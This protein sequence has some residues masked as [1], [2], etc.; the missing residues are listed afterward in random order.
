MS[1]QPPQQQPPQQ[2][3]PGY[4]PQPPPGGYAYPPPQQ[5]PQMPPALANLV[6]GDKA[7][8]L[9]AAALIVGLGAAL[10][11]ML[12]TL[13]AVDSD[14]LADFG[15]GERLKLAFSA[16]DLPFVGLI[17][18]ALALYRGAG[19]G[20]TEGAKAPF[21]SLVTMGGTAV[22]GLTLL[23]ALFRWVGGLAAED[24]FLTAAPKIGTFFYD[25]GVLVVA[26]VAALWAFS[27]LQ[28][29]GALN[30]PAAPAG[31]PPQGYPQQYPPQG[32][33]QPPTQAPPTSQYPPQPP[34]A[35]PPTPP[36]P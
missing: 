6:Q 7:R 9:G 26:A 10:F 8:N 19:G 1:D 36:A 20:E 22:A 34:P 14:K 35:A 4:A 2:P 5:G 11:A 21:A 13:I 25:L 30:K 15:F 18:L 3:P 28:R 12:I 32:Y 31:Y 24:Y 17:L 23:F 29:S 16:I 33:Q 27:E